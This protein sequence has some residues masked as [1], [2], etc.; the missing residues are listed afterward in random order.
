[1][2]ACLF[3][4]NFFL[5]SKHE[6]GRIFVRVHTPTSVCVHA[7]DPETTMLIQKKMILIFIG[8]LVKRGAQPLTKQSSLTKNGMPLP[9]DE[10]PLLTGTG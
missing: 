8:S 2:A 4:E 7:L 1:M 9:L 5:D 6:P 3:S 10:H